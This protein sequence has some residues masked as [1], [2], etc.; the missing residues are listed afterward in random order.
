MSQALVVTGVLALVAITIAAASIAALAFTL[1][2][3][4]RYFVGYVAARATDKVLDLGSKGV[5]S[6]AKSVANEMKRHDPKRL[7]AEVIKLAQSKNGKVTLS[8]VVAA[9]DCPSATAQQCF[10]SLIRQKLC[11]PKSEGHLT[12]YIFENYLKTATVKSC[13]FCETQFPV[14]SDES[15]CPNCGGAIETKQTKVE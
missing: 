5:V 11:R 3:L 13:P 2:S 9:C 12:Y 4:S 6:A 10:G 7:E 1:R 14:R 15:T 8:D